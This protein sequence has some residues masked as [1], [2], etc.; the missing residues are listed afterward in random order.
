M[1]PSWIEL[2]MPRAMISLGKALLT[3]SYSI[4]E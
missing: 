3:L 2:R 1:L 4:K